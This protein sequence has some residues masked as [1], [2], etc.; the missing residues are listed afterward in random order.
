MPPHDKMYAIAVRDEDLFLFL[1]VKRNA[2][3]EVFVLF[4]RDPKGW[5]PHASYHADGTHHQKSYNHKSI[6][7]KR[8]KPDA[9][10]PEAANLI[11]TGIA[12]DE[13]RAINALCDPTNFSAVFEIPVTDLSAEKYRTM[14]SVDLTP[15]GGKPIITTG[16]QVLK[17]VTFKDTIPWI[18]AT[19]YEAG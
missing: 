8:A 18:V 11:T 7:R 13:P 2:K 19:L 4:P 1:R 12:S 14:I 5:N 3:G 17:Q 9:A 15:P 6:V 16:A 10:F